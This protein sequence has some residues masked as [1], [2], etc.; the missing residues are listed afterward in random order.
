MNEIKWWPK[1]LLE[2]FFCLG[3]WDIR[4]GFNINFHQFCSWS[5]NANERNEP[6]AFFVLKYALFLAFFYSTAH[7]QENLND[8]L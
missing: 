7:H 1:Y 4:L 6:E 8:N 2:F 5:L 3:P